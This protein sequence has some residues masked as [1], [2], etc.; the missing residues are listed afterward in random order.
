MS[1]DEESPPPTVESVLQQMEAL[2]QTQK[3]NSNPVTPSGDAAKL[4]VD[5][6]SATAVGCMLGYGLDWWLGISPWGLIGGLFVGCAAGAKLMFNQLK[7]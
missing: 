2:K 3:A 5:F 7:D 6:A 4:A 1:K